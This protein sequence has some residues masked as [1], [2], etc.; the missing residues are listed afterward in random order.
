MTKKGEKESLPTRKTPWRRHLEKLKKK[1]NLKSGR[2][3][4]SGLPVVREQDWPHE[5]V[6]SVLAGKM[7]NVNDIDEKAF[8]ACILNSLLER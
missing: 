7:Y 5:T 4:T 1:G 6:N 8:I 3:M 2:H